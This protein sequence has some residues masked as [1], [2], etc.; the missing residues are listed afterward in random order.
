MALVHS[1]KNRLIENKFKYLNEMLLVNIYL[2]KLKR[3]L[4]SI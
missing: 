4:K 3:T 1:I 2:I